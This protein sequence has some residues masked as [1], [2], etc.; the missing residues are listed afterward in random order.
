MVLVRVRMPCPECGK[1]ILLNQRRAMLINF[2]VGCPN[3]KAI[4]H[5]SDL[6][7]ELRQAAEETQSLTAKKRPRKDRRL[8]ET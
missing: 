5:T 3:C 8:V 2:E 4:L 7:K 1:E 6:M